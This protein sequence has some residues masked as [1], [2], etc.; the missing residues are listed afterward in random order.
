MANT[1][2]FDFKQ[3]ILT[4]ERAWLAVP[5]DHESFFVKVT[6]TRNLCSCEHCCKYSVP[7]S[8]WQIFFVTFSMANYLL[9]VSAKW[10]ANFL[11]YITCDKETLLLWTKLK[12]S[13]IG[14][15][16]VLFLMALELETLT[17]SLVVSHIAIRQQSLLVYA[18]MNLR[19]LCPASRKKKPNRVET[20]SHWKNN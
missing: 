8:I 7:N 20:R 17:T 11:C 13:A 2:Q 6:L 14:I 16:V 1:N 9:R 15:L 19:L 18:P 5:T 10:L 12:R 3:S 4:K